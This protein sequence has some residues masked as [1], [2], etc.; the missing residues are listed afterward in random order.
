[1]VI[2]SIDVAK[3]ALKLAISSREEEKVLEAEL[4]QKGILTVAVDVG[5][6]INSSIPKIIERA[7]VASKRNGIIED[8]HV[9]D[10]AVVG[11][12][13][14][15]IMQVAAKANGLNVGGKIGIARYGEHLS[16]CIFMSIGL[17]HLNEVVIGIG[18]RSIPNM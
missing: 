16:V 2:D 13:R 15:A 17:L 12:T 5:G 1:M 4:S 3:I 11:A 7:L 18:H 6:N 9:H 8:C 10:G 14:E